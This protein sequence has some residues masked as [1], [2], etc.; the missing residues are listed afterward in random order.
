ME[1]RKKKHLKKIGL[2]FRQKFR[3]IKER[4]AFEEKMANGHQ[5]KMVKP[6][7]AHFISFGKPNVLS[8]DLKK[9][10]NIKKIPTATFNK[11]I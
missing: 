9:V 2:T 8:K 10:Q 4:I 1:Y 7:S 3:E 11:E 5:H 6:D